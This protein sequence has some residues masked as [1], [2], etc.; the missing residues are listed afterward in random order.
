MKKSILILTVSL[1]LSGFSASSAEPAPVTAGKGTPKI[2]FDAIFADLGTNPANASQ[3]TMAGVFKF[4]NE[5]DGVLKVD[6]PQPSCGCTDA[7]AVPDTLA[8]GEQG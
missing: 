5:G 1:G 7:K 3:E 6:P 2:V 8:P 4:R